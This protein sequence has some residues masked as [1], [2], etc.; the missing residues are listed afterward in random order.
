MNGLFGGMFARGGAAAEV[1]DVAWLAA[2]ADACA[3]LARAHRDTLMVGRTLMQQAVPTTFG[4][5]AAGWLTAVD[6]ARARLADVRDHRLP[7]PLGGG[8][9]PPAGPGPPPG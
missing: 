2:M 7:P 4:L 8:G 5:T 9:R 1:N 6:A 3:R